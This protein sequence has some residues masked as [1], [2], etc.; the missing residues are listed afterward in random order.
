MKGSK[1]PRID[2]LAYQR[3]E[4]LQ[5]QGSLKN[6]AMFGL[7]LLVLMGAMTLVWYYQNQQA[8]AIK[9]ENQK[10]EQ[11][12]DKLSKTVNS[13]AASAEAVKSEDKRENILKKLEDE[14]QV[15]SGQLRKIYQLSIPSITVG[16]LEMKSNNELAVTA[17]CTSQTSFI[18]FLGQLRE[19][20]FIKEVKNISS[21]Y[22]EK[23]GEVTFNLTLVWE[24][25]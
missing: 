7:I 5:R 8:E 22:N 16:K 17:Y 14:A 13:S 12:I 19:L 9:L 10:L 3:E 21:K 4:Q 6:I 23:T 18:K 1:E 15:K 24:V 20:D 11:D 25:E 2:L